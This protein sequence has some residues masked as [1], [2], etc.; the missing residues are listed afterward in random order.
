MLKG[1]DKTS[2]IVI[3]RLHGFSFALAFFILIS[4]HRNFLS[5]REHETPD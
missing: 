3:R 5:S 4:D 2:D 1:T